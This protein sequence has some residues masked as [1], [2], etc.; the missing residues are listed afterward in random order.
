MER[1]GEGEG[2]EREIGAAEP[3]A[4][5]QVTDEGADQDTAR[6]GKPQ[7]GP[8]APAELELEERLYVRPGA[9]EQRVAEGV[10]AAESAEN[11]PTLAEHGDEQGHLHEL[12]PA[13][14]RNGERRQDQEG[15]Q[16]SPA[17]DACILAHRTLWPNRPVGRNRRIRMKIAEMVMSPRLSPR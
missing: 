1:L 3:V 8:R 9:E 17:G 13:S 11:V 14:G 15:Q 4:E 7:G 5:T 2:D 12:D 16:Y 6:D 10:L